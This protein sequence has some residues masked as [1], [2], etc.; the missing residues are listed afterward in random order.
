MTSRM[1]RPSG[2]MTLFGLGATLATMPTTDAKAFFGGP[3]V[4]PARIESRYS[5]SEVNAVGPA[6]PVEVHGSPPD[7]GTPEA[8][9]AQ[10]RMPHYFS[11]RNM[12][13]AQ[14]GQGG[15]RIVMSFASRSSGPAMCKS[16]AGSNQAESA[17]IVVAFAYC[18]D[19][20][21]TS[22]TVL[23]GGTKGPGDGDFSGAMRQAVL[24]L[25]PRGN[26]E[27]AL[28]RN[29]KSEA[30][31]MVASLGLDLAPS[32]QASPQ[33]SLTTQAAWTYDK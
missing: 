32:T 31:L 7:G 13:L 30:Q 10:M 23:R 26:R 25:L 21:F 24:V 9:V 12:E 8:I 14:P 22:G 11:V 27:H 19:D 2:L 28:I 18:F 5:A 15:P 29:E 33:K 6:M 16:P 20:L 1:L 4:Q 17:D 3:A